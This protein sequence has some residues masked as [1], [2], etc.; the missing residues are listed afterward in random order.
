MKPWLR[1]IPAASLAI[2]L[3]AL[4]VSAAFPR[5]NG[6]IPSTPV[7]TSTPQASSS[8]AD[9]S[10]TSPAAGEILAELSQ[11]RSLAA[12]VR[13]QAAAI[14]KRVELEKDPVVANRTVEASAKAISSE[15]AQ[16]S[17]IARK[18]QTH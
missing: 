3:S 10:T 13:A 14:R 5:A 6:A 9:A 17:S 15:L 12:R 1:I 16:L 11:A 18:L 4:L 2:G 8:P 7:P